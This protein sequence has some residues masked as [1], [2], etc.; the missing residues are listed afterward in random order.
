MEKKPY[1][2]I[3]ETLLTMQEAAELLRC[4]PETLRLEARRGN[5][6]AGRIGRD[7]R[8]SAKRLDEYWQARG[9][10]PLLLPEHE[11]KAFQIQVSDE[12][13]EQ[14]EQLAGRKNTTVSSLFAETLQRI[15]V[16]A[17]EMQAILQRRNDEATVNL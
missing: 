3:E 14:I 10:E 13:F 7:Y 11:G 4:H 15:L 5:L 17:K 2:K 6:K 9:G 8:V 16:E 1:Q 12:Q